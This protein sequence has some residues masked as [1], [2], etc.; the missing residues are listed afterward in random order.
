MRNLNLSE[1]FSLLGA[2]AFG[3]RFLKAA[4]HYSQ[5]QMSDWQWELL[6][7]LVRH[8]YDHVPFYRDLNGGASFHPDDLSLFGLYPLDFLSTLTPIPEIIAQLK[9]RRPDL[10][11]CYPSHL[12]QNRSRDD[13]SGSGAN[14]SAVHIGELG[15]VHPG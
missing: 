2:F 12:K 14:S 13:R 1:L 3:G 11:V 9:S 7:R 15:N 10:R 5:D 6:T 8:A 4:P